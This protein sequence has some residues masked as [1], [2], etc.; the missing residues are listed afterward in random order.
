METAPVPVF[1]PRRRAAFHGLR[2][3]LDVVVNEC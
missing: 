3:S 2:Y 1:D